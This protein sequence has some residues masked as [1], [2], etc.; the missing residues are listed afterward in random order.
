MSCNHFEDTSNHIEKI[1]REIYPAIQYRLVLIG[2]Y[3]NFNNQRCE[4]PFVAELSAL[5]NELKS[6]FFALASYE[7]K[8]VFPSVLKY[9]DKNRALANEQLPDI[10]E[11][12][13]LTRSKEK[14]LL[15]L[16]D[17]IN[18]RL[19]KTA[20][21]DFPQKANLN[22]VVCFFLSDFKTA[23]AKWNEML[24]DR[25]LNCAC[26]QVIRLATKTPSQDNLPH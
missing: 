15:K 26:F 3:S 2:S 13:S 12:I 19:H 4:D 23:K 16:C 7:T 9:F 24:K 10:N 5:A 18:I 21:A 8:L 22:A 25:L 17:E 20:P 6:I 11:L 14:Q 1:V